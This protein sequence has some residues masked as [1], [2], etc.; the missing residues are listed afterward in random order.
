MLLLGCAL[1]PC[2]PPANALPPHL[3]LPQAN[4]PSL[5]PLPTPHLQP[6]GALSLRSTVPFTLGGS[7]LGMY[8]RGT[9]NANAT[10]PASLASAEAAL[11]ALELQLESSSPG[12]YAITRS[13]TVAEMLRSQA[14]SEGAM[15]PAAIAAELL[16]AMAAGRWTPVKAP[17]SDFVPEAAPTD[18]AAAGAAPFRADRLSIGR[19]LQRLDACSSQ[20][21][22]LDVCIDRLVLVSPV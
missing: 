18:G 22:P 3:S 17:L 1:C 4:R 10:D 16:A 12:R 20:D 21:R 9:A 15:D 8:M 13:R 2:S 11:G 19:C 7:V 5:L 14:A 6:Y